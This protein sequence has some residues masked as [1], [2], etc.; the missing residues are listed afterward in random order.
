MSDTPH[1]DALRGNDPLA[2][3]STR[4]D[5]ANE[6]LGELRGI[7]NAPSKAW[8]V[9]Q[10][11]NAPE[12]LA[13]ASYSQ[14]DWF[15]DYLGNMLMNMLTSIQFSEMMYEGDEAT[16]ASKAKEGLEK[17]INNY[18]HRNVEFDA[19]K[20]FLKEHSPEELGMDSAM[21]DSA[22]AKLLKLE[23]QKNG[24]VSAA[25]EYVESGTVSTTAE[26][27]GGL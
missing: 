23:D 6:T 22:M 15:T 17:A 1:Q 4:I 19:L 5:A 12:Q 10:N 20:G 2:E 3:L 8:P 13:D 25:S 27:G 24:V 26:R 18:E 11:P 9:T 16:I 21:R 7:L 14:W